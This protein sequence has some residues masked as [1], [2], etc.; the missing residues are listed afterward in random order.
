VHRFRLLAVVVVMAAAAAACGGG[1]G[2]NDD[3]AAPAA[4]TTVAGVTTVAVP[5]SGGGTT[6][7]GTNLSLR[8]TDLHL[9]NSEESDNAVRI[10]L[11]AGVTTASVSIT[12]LP[13]P[14]RVISVCQTNELDRR[15]PTAVCRMPAPGDS[16]TVTLGNGASGV[17]IMQVGVNGSGPAANTTTLSDVTIRYTASS[18]EFSV[19]LPQIEAGE[20]GGRP[21]FALT[22]P[23][24]GGSYRATLTWTVIQVFGGTPS[25]AQVELLQGG[26][27]VNKAAGSGL[28]VRLTGDVP[29]PVGDVALRVLN[30]G[31]SAL[32]NLKLAA[33]LP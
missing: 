26:N 31:S 7:P 8:I 17:E 28:E 15:L 2:S 4:T 27:T 18:R 6:V 12:G 3:A 5:T 20:A 9:A 16:S 24:P 10:L 11:P 19:R 30:T 14:N 13:S 33:L 32:V 29:A 22:P 1:G 23:G 25:T 21:T